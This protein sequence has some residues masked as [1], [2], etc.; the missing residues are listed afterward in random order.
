MNRT[1]TGMH[2]KRRIGISDSLNRRGDVTTEAQSTH[3][4]RRFR[5]LGVVLEVCHPERSEGPGRDG[6]GRIFRAPITPRSLA[7]LKIPCYSKQYVDVAP[8][9]SRSW[10]EHAYARDDT[11]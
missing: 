9:Q 6:G 7:T 5:G 10:L 1:V 8:R 3:A 4:P 2:P 11:L